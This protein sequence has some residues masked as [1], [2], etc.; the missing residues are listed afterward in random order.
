MLPVWSIANDKALSV[1]LLRLAAVVAHERFDLHLVEPA[2]REDH[3]LA[4]RARHRRI[5]TQARDDSIVVSLDVDA[6]IVLE[7]LLSV[8]RYRQDVAQ[9]LAQLGRLHFL[10]VGIRDDRSVPGDVLELFRSA[11]TCRR[12][13]READVIRD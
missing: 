12:T 2:T 10:H 6:C 8:L 13:G 9:L 4:R 3:S 7:L 5:R 1:V 11:G